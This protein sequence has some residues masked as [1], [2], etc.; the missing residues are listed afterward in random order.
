MARSAP[1][2][3]DRLRREVERALRD[4]ARCR[5]GPPAACAPGA[6]R[7]PGERRVDLRPPPPRGDGR[8]ARPVARRA[9]RAP[10]ARRSARTTTAPGRCSASRS[11]CSATTATPRAPTSAPSRSRPTTPGTPTT[12]ATS[13]TSRS[14]RPA[15]ALPLLARATSTQPARARHRREL[16]A[17]PRP[18]REGGRGQARA[19]PRHPPG[20]DR[21]PGGA[22]PLAR[23]RRAAALAGARRAQRREARERRRARRPRGRGARGPGRRGRPEEAEAPAHEAQRGGLMRDAPGLRAR[24]RPSCGR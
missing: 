15:D 23:R 19:P 10:R 18:L 3:V 22:L 7:R 1:G 5:G 11:R 12:W 8:G 20:R 24:R 13:T 14:S 21:R 16:R 2:E 9:L 6:R 4:E 17:R